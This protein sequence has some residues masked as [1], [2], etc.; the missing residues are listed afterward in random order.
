MRS[1]LAEDLKSGDVGM[2][3]ILQPLSSQAEGLISLA[4]IEGQG[5]TS[6]VTAA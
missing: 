5:S 6:G 3:H 1:C 2:T 4:V